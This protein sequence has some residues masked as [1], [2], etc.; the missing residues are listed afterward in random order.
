VSARTAKRILAENTAVQYGIFGII[1]SSGF[2]PPIKFL[3]QFL[4]KGSDPC[5]QDGRMSNWTPFIISIQDYLVVKE[6]WM[7]SH[8]GASENNLDADSWDDWIQIIL[9]D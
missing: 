3:N 2:F 9:N 8:P 7:A 6:W 1:D 4:A 5:D